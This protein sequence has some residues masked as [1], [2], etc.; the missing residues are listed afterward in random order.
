MKRVLD[1]LGI[2]ALVTTL[3]SGRNPRSNDF[4]L[5]SV[6]AGE[7]GVAPLCILPV[8]REKK[9]HKVR[10]GLRATVFRSPGEP[11]IERGLSLA[12]MEPMPVPLWLSELN[13]WRQMAGLR[14]VVEN[15]HLSYG[16]H[17]HARYLVVQGPPDPAGFRAY[18]RSL[19]PRAH[20]ENSHSA[21]YTAAGAEAAMG[22]P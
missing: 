4:G 22:G 21:F 8:P 11:G 6:K 7:G 5:N 15:A 20:L 9:V 19:G 1:L 3:T 13:Q 16:S 17:E 2:L 18:D 10:Y 14:R 12:T